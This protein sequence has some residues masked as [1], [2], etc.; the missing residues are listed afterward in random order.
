MNIVVKLLKVKGRARFEPSLFELKL[1]SNE[2]NSS[3]LKLISG[4]NAL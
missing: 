2:L 3:E 1:G 4:F